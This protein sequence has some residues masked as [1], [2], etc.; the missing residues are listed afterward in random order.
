MVNE[1]GLDT[2]QQVSL[3]VVVGA[4]CS[5]LVC[6]I[7]W[8][9]S[10]TVNLQENMTKTLDSFSTLLQMLTSTFLLE[11]PIH[12]RQEK[13]QKAIDSHQASFTS[14]K[15][16][17]KEAHSEWFYGGPSGSSRLSSGK[18]YEDAVDCLN[19]LAQHLNGLR[20]G[21]RLQFDLTKAHTEGKVVIKGRTSKMSSSFTAKAGRSQP[22]ESEEDNE[23]LQ[24]AAHMF[25]D[26]VDDLGPPMNALSVCD[27]PHLYAKR[28]SSVILLDDLHICAET[29]TRSIR[30]AA[31]DCK[32]RSYQTTRV[33][34]T[35]GW[36]REGT[37]HF[38]EHE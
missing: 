1:G 36:H 31:T 13:L 16:N 34:S 21:I 9:Q 37:F 35:G 12:V 4:L 15:K 14:L 28:V 6:Y 25:G 26:L 32:A 7:I 11:E 24:A 29:S 8:P 19:R 30:Q 2:L 10:A 20:S 22:E 5:N 3:I 23:L 27:F 17:L 18:A 33:S 38:R